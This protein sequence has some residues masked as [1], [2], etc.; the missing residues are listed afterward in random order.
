MKLGTSKQSRAFYRLSDVE[1]WLAK[2]MT[3]VGGA[4]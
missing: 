1:L 4:A 2:S 3:E